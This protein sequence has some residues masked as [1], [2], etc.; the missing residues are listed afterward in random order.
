VSS[1]PIRL[2]RTFLGAAC[3]SLALATHAIA[4]PALWVVQSDTATVYLFG[5]FNALRPGI[6]WQSAALANAIDEAQEIWLEVADQ[7]GMTAMVPLVLRLGRNPA[8]TLSHTVT[9]DELHRVDA[10]L[11]RLG[12][13]DGAANVEAFRPWLVATMLMVAPHRAAG[14]DFRTGVDLTVRVEAAERAKP[15]RGFATLEQQTRLFAY[16]PPDAELALLD[17]TLKAFDGEDD[18]TRALFDA[19]VAGDVDSVARLT[20][21]GTP[22]ALWRFLYRD[23]DIAWAGQIAGMLRNPGT[24]LVAVGIGHLVGDGGILQ[25]LTAGGVPIERIE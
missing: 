19:W 11:R 9:T 21:S 3:V 2:V 14:L 18:D 7:G 12:F 23:R 15:V 22:P 5:T 1:P 13:V 17:S 6:P 20:E 8:Q 24:T 25:T 10:A 4:T 16:L